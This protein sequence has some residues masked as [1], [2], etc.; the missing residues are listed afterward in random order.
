MAEAQTE[1]D[2]S[3]S[4]TVA[5]DKY[6]WHVNKTGFPIKEATWRKMWGYV[7]ATHPDGA[8]IA[9]AICGKNHKRVPTPTPPVVS[10]VYATQEN[11]FSVQKYMD[12]LQYNHT[13]TQFFDIKKTRPLFRY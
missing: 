7:L 12:E 5:I 3:E 6:W 8:I 13:G 11:M 9:E 2:D 1:N 10:M 4:R